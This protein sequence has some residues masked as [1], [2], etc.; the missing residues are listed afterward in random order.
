MS[1]RI[2]VRL[3]KLTWAD[4]EQIKLRGRAESVEIAGAGHQREKPGKSE[5][6]LK[7]EIAF[8]SW[9]SRIWRSSDGSLFHSSGRQ[10]RILN[11]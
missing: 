10:G 5:S 2:P 11:S 8:R 9:S 7:S 6:T 3:L 4:E 1:P